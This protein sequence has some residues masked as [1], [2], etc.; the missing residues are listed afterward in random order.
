MIQLLFLQF[1]IVVENGSE[2]SEGEYEPNGGFL[3]KQSKK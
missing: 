1:P 2:L 3:M